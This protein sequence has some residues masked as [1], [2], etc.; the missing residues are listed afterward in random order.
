[1]ETLEQQPNPSPSV[2]QPSRG[3][4]LLG[5]VPLLAAVL[6][7]ILMDID[8]ADDQSQH[9]W[10]PIVYYV[11]ISLVASLCSILYHAICNGMEYLK[12]YL[13]AIAI[14]WPV[15]A[16][17]FVA[18]SQ[19]MFDDSTPDLVGVLLLIAII[20]SG[21][22][23]FYVGTM[24]VDN[25]T[26]FLPTRQNLALAIGCCATALPAFLFSDEIGGWNRR[27]L[28]WPKWSFYLI[29]AAGGALG[30]YLIMYYVLLHPCWIAHVVS[31]PVGCVGGLGLL[32]FYLQHVD[33]TVGF[34]NFLVLVIGM[35]PGIPVYYLARCIQLRTVGLDLSFLTDDDYVAM[36]QME[37]EE[38]QSEM[39]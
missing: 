19:Y 20:G 1:M 22:L 27:E 17:F 39:V 7:T 32:A 4:A 11:I 14:S 18:L 10:P 33:E 9:D 29:T 16:V 8:M 38:Q 5:L 28:G 23:S 24:L 37:Q 2:P 36:V 6:T 15:S 21:Y 25:R 3:R 30:A 26:D 13:P 35:L 34:I 31:W 12:H